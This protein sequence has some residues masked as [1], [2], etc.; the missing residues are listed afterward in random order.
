MKQ[1]WETDTVAKFEGD[2]LRIK[3]VMENTK[4]KQMWDFG[5]RE[6]EFGIGSPRNEM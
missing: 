5:L 1:N 6:V 3:K 2:W 4:N